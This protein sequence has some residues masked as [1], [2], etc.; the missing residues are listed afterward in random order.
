MLPGGDGGATLRRAMAHSRPLASPG[1]RLVLLLT[2]AILLGVATM[3]LLKALLEA[4][5]PQWG[6]L[7]DTVRLEPAAGEGSF[8]YDLGRISRR[9]LVLVLLLTFIAGRR[10]VPWGDLVREGM[11]RGPHAVA[12]GTYGLVAG[13]ALAAVYTALLAVTGNVGWDPAGPAYLAR[14]IPEILVGAAL[15][16]LL[17]EVFFRGVLFTAMLRDWGLAVALVVSNLIFA[18]LHGISGGYR[19]APGWD[20]GIGL[21][22]LR[23]YYT[24][25]GSLWPD[26][27]LVVGLVIL[28]ALLCLLLVR[29]G[30]LWAPIALHAALV[31]GTKLLKVFFDR[32]DDFPVWLLGDRL[33]MVSGVATWAI[34]LV[35]LPVVLILAPRRP[36]A[37]VDP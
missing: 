28:G 14:K 21:E 15:I 34:M 31:F 37:D 12:S 30:S 10:L 11:R 23:A 5:L 24:T 16:G 18:V 20:A 36:F 19:V 2:L 6:P 8:T 4:G 9:W 3:P 1:L 27:R 26:V 17:E 13:L 25:D 35:A 33:F 7:A 22:L 29:T 32:G